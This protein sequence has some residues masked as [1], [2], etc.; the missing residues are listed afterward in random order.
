MAGNNTTKAGTDEVA[1]TLA[2]DANGGRRAGSSETDVFCFRANEMGIPDR[3]TDDRTNEE[4]G[5][6]ELCLAFAPVSHHI[7]AIR[8]TAADFDGYEDVVPAQS[9]V[10]SDPPADALI[11]SQAIDDML[12]MPANDNRAIASAAGSA[13]AQEP[14]EGPDWQES[15]EEDTVSE[16]LTDH[17]EPPHSAEWEEPAALPFAK[18]RLVDAEAAEAP[19]ADEVLA[20]DALEK[21]V[22]EE[23]AAD[24]LAALEATIAAAAG[25]AHQD[26]EEDL[27]SAHAPDAVGEDAHIGSD[28]GPAPAQGD[29]DAVP[30]GDRDETL[31]TAA[32]L[33]TEVADLDEQVADASDEV[34]SVEEDAQEP[35][36][37]RE[38]IDA[39]GDDADADDMGG[40]DEDHA[41]PDDPD[42][43]EFTHAG[44]YGGKAAQAGPNGDAPDGDAPDG[45]DDGDDGLP[46]VDADD[47][48]AA[49]ADDEPVDEFRDDGDP[50]A[51]VI[52]IA[53]A[54]GLKV[55]ATPRR[56]PRYAAALL[57]GGIGI[58]GA[59]WMS[60][61]V[62]EIVASLTTTPPAAQDVVVLPSAGSPGDASGWQSAS[63]Q[64]PV[65][66]DQPP[67]QAL[68]VLTADATPNA[69][70]RPA[71]PEAG[72]F[73]QNVEMLAAIEPSQ[74]TPVVN[75]ETQM[76]P[77]LTLAPTK[78]PPASAGE[79]PASVSIVSNQQSATITLARLAP[80]LP[81]NVTA[82]GVAP[83]LQGGQQTPPE[84]MLPQG[85]A[86]TTDAGTAFEPVGNLGPMPLPAEARILPEAVWVPD[87][88]VK[89]AAS[90][91][92]SGLRVPNGTDWLGD[93]GATI[94]AANG[95][96]VS[97]I[98]ELVAALSSTPVDPKTGTG[99]VTLTVSGDGM[100]RRD[101][102]HQ[103]AFLRTHVTTGGT[104]FETSFDGR[105]WRTRVTAAGLDTDLQVGDVIVRD[106]GIKEKFAN[107]DTSERVLNWAKSN[108]VAD[109]KFAI[110]RDGA[111][112]SAAIS[113]DGGPLTSQ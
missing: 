111:V 54:R 22:A 92:P 43:Q 104:A 58:A 80:A 17:E 1:G 101:V 14:V 103:T 94:V 62:P 50:D 59:L 71:S 20:S 12:T 97:S 44:E 89:L 23:I 29:L 107:P 83:Q 31:V 110:L 68:A 5:D 9:F 21:L 113:A 81:G 82:E 37:F 11:M 19:L 73:L 52:P 42:A 8:N 99:E 61:S 64:Q 3:D 86:S 51:A 16:L 26:E 109:V 72:S 108:N 63:L 2:G 39:V 57:L 95:W 47:F 55:S 45:D 6:Y 18:P 4:D 77:T 76:P 85:L 36:E 40:P 35:G 105:R 93:D 96:Y 13:V 106:F 98:D 102:V 91:K 24:E 70:I 66:L 87:L 69:V 38:D 84:Q 46:R 88:G 67:A 79:T 15:N 41:A 112:A 25:E 56:W 28:D 90:D 32:D 65:D 7:V 53:P 30:D 78:T 10:M 60:R 74:D 48:A 27:L 33:E 34:P 75:A 100:P 49:L